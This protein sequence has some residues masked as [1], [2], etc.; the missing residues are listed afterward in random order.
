[1][2]K[3]CGLI[4]DYLLYC[5][6]LI[7]GR[8]MCPRHVNDALQRQRGQLQV[9]EE[10]KGVSRLSRPLESATRTI[11]ASFIGEEAQ[12]N[13]TITTNCLLLVIEPCLAALI[14]PVILWGKILTDSP[15]KTPTPGANTC[16]L[17]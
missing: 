10:R 15:S 6:Y 13:N 11:S 17:P 1:M 16:Y 14:L 9:G 8:Y 7:L 2:I 3:L 4:A 12:V 5:T